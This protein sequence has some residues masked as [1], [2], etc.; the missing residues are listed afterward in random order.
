MPVS[1]DQMRK[2]MSFF[3]TGVTI[4]TTAA[5]DGTPYGLTVNAFTSVSLDPPLI[6]VCL[7]SRISGLQ[8]FKEGGRFGVSVLSRRQRDLATHFA[9]PGTDRTQADYEFGETGV[10]LI[11]AALARLECIVTTIHPGGDHAVLLASVERAEVL[12]EG[13]EPLLYYRSGYAGLK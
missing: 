1:S 10:P 2:T 12:E 5:S 11:K 7:D 13:E 8:F 4:V 6:L 9:T 3:A